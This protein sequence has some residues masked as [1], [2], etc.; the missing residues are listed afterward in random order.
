[1]G[2]FQKLVAGAVLAGLVWLPGCATRRFVRDQIRPVEQ[3]TQELERKNQEA[4]AQIAQLDEKTSRGLS[5]VEE[6]ALSAE[7]R[8]VEAGRGAQQAREDAERASQV[9]QSA[10]QIG[11]QNQSR[12]SELAEFLANSDK[13]RLVVE[14]SVLF[15]FNRSRLDAEARQKLEGLVKRLAASQRYVIEVV[16]YADPSGR[17]DYNL[18]L[19]RRRAEAVV[20]YLV[21]RD[22]P[23]RRIHVAGLGEMRLTAAG[24]DHG[25]QSPALRRRL[26]RRVEI[27]VYAPE[28]VLA[29][30]KASTQTAENRPD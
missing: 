16:G 26:A 19:S 29:T 9:A 14:E 27:K 5:R 13:Y 23:L 28:A 1:M 17:E 30:A 6:R 11:E 24:A 8:A 4:L 12:L 10:R 20:Q 7:N 22:V 15:G 21:N 3:R 2:G 18:A 25:A